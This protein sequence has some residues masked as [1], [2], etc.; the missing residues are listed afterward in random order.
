MPYYITLT[1]PSETVASDLTAFPVMVR[2]SDL[3]SGFWDH[4][5]NDGGDIRVK[6]TAGAQLPQDLIWIDCDNHDGLLVFKADV[7]AG[8]DN[9]WGI[10]FGNASLSGL[11]PTDPNGR[12]AVWDDYDSVYFF[13][14]IEDR[15]GAS[16]VVSL[17]G[18]SSSS[19]HI[20]G[21]HDR[22]SCHQGVAW[23]GTYFY[24]VD[25]DEIVKTDSAGN[26]IT[27][28]ATPL[29]SANI[30]DTNHCGDPE[31]HEGYLYIPIEK[32]PNDPYNNQHIAVFAASDLSFVTSYDISTQAFEASSIAYNPSDGYLYISSHVTGNTIYK[33]TTSGSYIGSITLSVSRTEIQG[34]TIYDEHIYVSSDTGDTIYKYQLDGTYVD[35]VFKSI[36]G[37]FLEGLSH[38]DTGL[39][40]LIDD[41]DGGIMKLENPTGWV[42]LNYGDYVRINDLSKRDTWTLGITANIGQGQSNNNQAIASYTQSGSGSDA[43]RATMGYKRSSTPYEISI[44]DSSNG[45]VNSSLEYPV[46][47]VPRRLH[48]V[49]NSTTDRKIY[50]DGVQVGVDT[51]ITARPAGN[52]DCVYIGR[53]DNDIAERMT[54]GVTF[55]YLKNGVLSEDWIAAEYDNISDPSSFYLVSDVNDPS[56][57]PATQMPSICVIT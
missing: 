19:F 56:I 42:S 31:V 9:A 10:H 8:S 43:Y 6:T 15:T 11:S 5:K 54:G 38:H 16:T 55:F 24:I 33:Y 7:L 34:I 51:G 13:N 28:N 36:V 35:A 46:F 20:T 52:G 23:D 57:P 26:E 2:L 4:V 44:W 37:G 21:V 50:A 14:D 49:Y 29:A 48:M 22:K 53:P 41:S 25:T 12:N 39:Y 32:Y 18:T 3:P 27:R 17:Y 30:P 40:V 47:Y 1:I 45:W